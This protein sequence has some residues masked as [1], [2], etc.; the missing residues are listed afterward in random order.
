[1]MQMASQ[2]TP[3]TGDDVQLILFLSPSYCTKPVT[4][5]IWMSNLKGS[6]GFA[7]FAVNTLTCAGY[8]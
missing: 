8:S 3:K 4:L 7:N 6:K 1:M 2:F 5:T